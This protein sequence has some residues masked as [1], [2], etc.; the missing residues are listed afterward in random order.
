MAFSAIRLSNI[1]PDE[2]VDLADASIGPVGSTRNRGVLG[3]LL[4][5]E[6]LKLML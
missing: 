2:A 1:D 5:D 6:S 3:L 4:M